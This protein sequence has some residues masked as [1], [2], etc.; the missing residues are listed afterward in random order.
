MHEYIINE[1]TGS[2][3]RLWQTP[4]A[5]SSLHYS[6]FEA[7]DCTTSLTFATSSL[8]GWPLNLTGSNDFIW[9]LNEADYFVGYHGRENRGTVTIDLGTGATTLA[10][11]PSASPPPPSPIATSASRSSTVSTGATVGI[12]VG[13]VALGLIFGLLASPLLPSPRSLLGAAPSAAATR[14]A[15]TKDTMTSSSDVKLQAGP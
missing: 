2:A 13:A 12:A 15:T 4:Y 11:I 10:A 7:A 8:A 3:F 6:S 1:H 5:P 9:A 14:T